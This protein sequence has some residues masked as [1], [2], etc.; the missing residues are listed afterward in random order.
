MCRQHEGQNS[1]VF[2][3][4]SQLQKQGQGQRALCIRR[5][6]CAPKFYRS[7]TLTPAIHLVHIHARQSNPSIHT[8]TS[9][10]YIQ[11]LCKVAAMRRILSEQCRVPHTVA[12]MAVTGARVSG[13]MPQL[14]AKIN[15]V[16]PIPGVYTHL[17]PWVRCLASFWQAVPISTFSQ[18]CCFGRLYSI[19]TDL[20]PRRTK[21][22]CRDP[23]SPPCSR[24]RCACGDMSEHMCIW[25]IGDTIVACSR[26]QR[27]DHT[28]MRPVCG[29]K[30]R[31]RGVAA[32]LLTHPKRALKA[33]AIVDDA[34]AELKK[35]FAAIMNSPR[36]IPVPL[37]VATHA[38][39]NIGK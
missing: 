33:K 13:L 30:H 5:H 21:T 1:P 18:Q 29:C 12:D 17:T 7:S 3:Q 14:V 27:A 23:C 38:L 16:S 36:P 15:E 4:L 24:T 19:A 26:Y 34:L 2:A 25:S 20:S 39:G 6:T 22:F 35:T 10:V 32:F 28:V 9:Y 31:F 8:C 37:I 11:I